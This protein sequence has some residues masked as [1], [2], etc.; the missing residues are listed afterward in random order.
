MR[1][2][3]RLG[4]DVG[5]VR[6]GLAT[7][8]PSGLIATPVETLRR[9]AGDNADIRRVAELSDE[10]GAIEVV[11]GLPLNLRGEDTK[12]TQAARDW[13]ATLKRLRPSVRVVLV[14]ERLTSVSAHRSLTQSG[15]SGRE[16]RARVD[17]QAAV[18]ILQSAL[19]TERLTGHP[20]GTEVG[21]RKPRARKT[22]D[23]N[24]SGNTH[25]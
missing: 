10:S 6:V 2:G 3:V 11:V 1:P 5:T 14:D 21:G 7:S 8:D 17:Q 23:L 4:V 16:Q 13:A 12:S 9:S 24:E 15:V 20:A 25:A 22:R 18:E 19:E